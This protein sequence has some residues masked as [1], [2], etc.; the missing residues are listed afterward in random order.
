MRHNTP[1]SLRAQRAPGTLMGNGWLRESPR[2][3]GPW[4]WDVRSKSA[5][6]KCMFLPVPEEIRN[7]APQVSPAALP[8]RPQARAP[9]AAHDVEPH[10][11]DPK[12]D[13]RQFPAVAG[14]LLAARHPAAAQMMKQAKPAEPARAWWEDPVALGSLLILL[15]PVG[16]AA[17]WSSKRYSNDARWAL[18]VMTALM[19][20]LVSAVVIAGLAMG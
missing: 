14:G 12:R 8:P 4:K 11:H 3:M 19:M 15:P 17:V 2:N 9:I 5:L 1:R 16:L 20:C 7:L 18:T 10:R 6:R 13:V